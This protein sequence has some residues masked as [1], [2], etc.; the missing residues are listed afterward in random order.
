MSKGKDYKLRPADS[1]LLIYTR[2]H[3]D[4]ILSGL[5]STIA[6]DRL[7]YKVTDKTKFTL[8]DDYGTLNITEL[9]D[10]PEENP[11]RTASEDGV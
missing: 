1:N 9:D 2:N 5:I 8:S 10:E 4:A 3:I 6:M 11:I 7:G